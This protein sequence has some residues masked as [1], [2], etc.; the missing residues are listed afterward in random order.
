MSLSL[1]LLPEYWISLEVEHA[2]ILF[3]FDAT[4]FQAP[5]NQDFILFQIYFSVFVC[6]CQIHPVLNFLLRGRRVRSIH[7]FIGSLKQWAHLVYIN[8]IVSGSFDISSLGR[9]D[10]SLSENLFSNL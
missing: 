10:V 9:A 4:F 1:S 7:G 5:Q 2:S 8:P 6:V 3:D